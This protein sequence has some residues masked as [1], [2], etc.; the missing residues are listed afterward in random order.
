MVVADFTAKLISAQPLHF[1]DFLESLR[2]LVTGGG[3]LEGLPFFR[4]HPFAPLR[5][6]P[7]W[8]FAADAGSNFPTA[9]RAGVQL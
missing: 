7:V 2:I 3:R 5:L 9:G 6:T 1:S 8:S 4:V